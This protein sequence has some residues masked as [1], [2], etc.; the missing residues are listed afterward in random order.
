MR[1]CFKKYIRKIGNKKD[2]DVTI[3]VAQLERNNNKCYTSAFIYIYIQI[4]W[5]LMMKETNLDKKKLL[6]KI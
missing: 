1:K 5:F 2:N 4:M 6:I 3:N